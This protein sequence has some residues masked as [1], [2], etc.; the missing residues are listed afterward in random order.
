VAFAD[1][2]V[3]ATR[4]FA[5][6]HWWVLLLLIAAAFALCTIG[7][8]LLPR[9]D[10]GTGILPAKPGPPR[11]APSLRSPLALAW[12][13]HRGTLIGW[14]IGFAV[15][16][17][18]FGS[19]AAGIGDIVGT[20]DQSKQILERMGGASGIV[21]AYLGTIVS[22]L[23]MIASL[24]AVQ[25]SLRMRSEESAMRVEPLL[26]TAV[27]RLRWASSHLM[28]ALLGSGLI[29]A[30]GGVLAGLLHGLRIGDVSGQV[31]TLLG[32]ALA[33]LP[34]VWVVAG[35]SVLLFGFLPTYAT[36]PWGVAAFF[37]M[38]GLFG[39]AAQLSQMV[40]DVSPFTHLPKLPMP[41]SPRRRCSGSWRSPLLQLDS[42]S[43]VSTGATLGNPSPM[44]A[45]CPGQV[46]GPGHAFP[47][48]APTRS[49]PWRAVIRSA[50][51]RFRSTRRF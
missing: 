13:L 4:P 9:R 29:L 37:L 6:D 25:A 24:Y 22:M 40:L 12:R 27:S 42:V 2:L 21:A 32:A 41:S 8:A 30:T 11:A 17:A 5:G 35:I 48:R 14:L 26:A 45:C 3:D 7:F 16:G 28:F 15:M 51:G 1:R 33:Q 20:S 31:P 47:L 23:S 50:S 44:G 10:F 19:L 18:L 39:A 38:I 34:A 49:R 36:A 43:R 46:G